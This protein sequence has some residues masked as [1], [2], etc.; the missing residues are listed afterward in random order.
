MP[1]W[2]LTI[3]RLALLLAASPLLFLTPAK[4]QT[5]PPPTPATAP[6]AAV[7]ARAAA[8]AAGFTIEASRIAVEKAASVAVRAFAERLAAEHQRIATLVMHEGIPRD[9]KQETML[10]QLRSAPSSQFDGIFLTMQLK[11]LQD[12]VQLHESYRLA[13]TDPVYKKLAAEVAPILQQQLADAAK[14]AGNLGTAT[15]ARFPTFAAAL[16]Q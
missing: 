7:Y 9:D 16:P 2:F 10:S 5:P 12:T 14:I 3:P 13:G 11:A 8:M 15:Q 4:A 6:S 1:R